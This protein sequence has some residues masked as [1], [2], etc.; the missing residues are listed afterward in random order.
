MDVRK[1]GRKDVYKKGKQDCMDGEREAN[2]RHIERE[3]GQQ[4]T[5]RKATKIQREKPT[6]H[7]EKSHQD[8][9]RKATKIQRE[10]P[11]RYAIVNP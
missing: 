9:E 4:D 11:P 7:R 5:E 3:R 6:R 10:K 2:K 1:R 8:T